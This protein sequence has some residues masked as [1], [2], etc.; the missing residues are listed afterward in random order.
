[1]LIDG[2]RVAF[3]AEKFRADWTDD[4]HI[5]LVAVIVNHCDNVV[6]RRLSFATGFFRLITCCPLEG[7][8]GLFFRVEP[9]WLVVIA[10]SCL[11][12]WFFRGRAIFKVLQ[13]CSVQMR[14]A[15]RGS[16]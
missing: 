6:S 14:S 7:L 5:I 16:D 15:Y 9:Y 2:I 3:R 1:M 4:F 13:S 8:V 10:T 12:T 11:V